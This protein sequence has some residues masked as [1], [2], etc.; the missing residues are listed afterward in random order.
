MCDLCRSE[1][2]FRV[3]SV[4]V[5]WGLWRSDSAWH[6]P[7][8]K[9]V[10]RRQEGL[11]T[12]AWRR[13]RHLS[14]KFKTTLQLLSEILSPKGEIGTNRKRSSNLTR[15]SFP[16]VS[17]SQSHETTTCFSNAHFPWGGFHKLNS[18]HLNDWEPNCCCFHI[19]RQSRSRLLVYLP[20]CPL[21][22]LD[23]VRPMQGRHW[24]ASFPPCFKDSA[25]LF[26]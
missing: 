22:S 18:F 12:P 25:L 2:N 23:P 10:L 6:L 21:Q 5:P 3:D 16:R 9:L 13:L 24:A 19:C 26:C 7:S 15:F 8:S 20:P 17:E 4:L 11:V 14:H 1:D